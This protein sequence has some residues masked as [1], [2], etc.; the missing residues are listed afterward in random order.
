M[1]KG[2]GSGNIQNLMRQA[3]KMQS[4]LQEQTKKAEEELEKAVLTATSGG[5]MIEVKIGGN[6]KLISVKINPQVVDSDDVEML[7]DLIISCVNEA[8][9]KAVNLEKE[10]KP[11]LPT[12]LV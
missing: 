3:Q 12:G 1:F 8:I 4:D 2:F 9:E 7:E 5:G 10:L 11:A 6:K